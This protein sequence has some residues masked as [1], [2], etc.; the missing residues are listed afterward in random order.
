VVKRVALFFFFLAYSALLGHNLIPHTHDDHHEHAEA[1]AHGSDHHHHDHEKQNDEGTLSLLLADIIHAPGSTGSFVN[2]TISS[3]FK[4]SAQS[5]FLIT[6]EVSIPPP[7]TPPMECLPDLENE[8]IP[9]RSV[10][11]ASLRAP[12]VA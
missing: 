10:T 9:S 4:F 7:D 2:H 1:T 8:K 5:Y 12:P 3:V 11:H 6:Q